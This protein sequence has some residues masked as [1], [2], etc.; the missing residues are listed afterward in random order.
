MKG[1]INHLI[2]E[3]RRE[4]AVNVSLEKQDIAQLPIHLFSSW[5]THAVSRHEFEANAMMLAT[6]GAGAQPHAR[7][8]LVKGLYEDGLT[9]YTN[10]QSQKSIDMAENP[11]MSA[12]FWWPYCYRQVRVLGRVEK[13]P[14]LVSDQYF[15]KRDRGAQLAAWASKQSQALS[16]PDELQASYQAAVDRFAGKEVPRPKCWGGY[17]ILPVEFEF[18][19]G[20]KD[21]LHERLCYRMSDGK[22]ERSWLWP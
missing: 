19:Q 3:S 5:F 15:A 21:R 1:D 11:K 18:W 12:V 8:V 7:Y 4:Y 20:A 6:V 17:V 14:G 22:W 9:F 10:Y 13:L 2:Q 16:L